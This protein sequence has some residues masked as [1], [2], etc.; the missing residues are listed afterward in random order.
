MCSTCVK[1]R[2]ER[3]TL[4]FFAFVVRGKCFCRQSLLYFYFLAVGGG[5]ILFATLLKLFFFLI[6]FLSPFLDLRVFL[7]FASHD[8]PRRCWCSLLARTHLTAL[9]KESTKK[10]SHESAI[11]F[12]SPPFFRNSPKEHNRTRYRTKGTGMGRGGGC[13]DASGEKLWGGGERKRERGCHKL[14]E[15]KCKKASRNLREG[16]MEEKKD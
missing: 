1:T 9:Q 16:E 2:T 12:C 3:H 10:K 7:F 4:L 13:L 15:K 6:S 5:G 14:V 11:L 8:A